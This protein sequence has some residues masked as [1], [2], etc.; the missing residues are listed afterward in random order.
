MAIYKMIY[1]D[2]EDPTTHVL[3]VVERYVEAEHRNHARELFE[4]GDNSYSGPRHVVA[5]PLGP[6][7]PDKVP[8]DAQWAH[9]V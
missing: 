8:A 7:A 1:R 5:G 6:I 3:H 2:E 9:N 4:I